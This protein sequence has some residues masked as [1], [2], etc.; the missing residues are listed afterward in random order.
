M[1]KTAYFVL[2]FIIVIIM[3]GYSAK[4]SAEIFATLGIGTTLINSTLKVADVGYNYNGWEIQGTLIE[5]GTTKN[6]PQDY[7]KLASLSYL[8]EPS[9]GYMGVEPYFRLG[10][11]YNPDSNL[12]GT[13][14][15]K[16]GI[17]VDFNEVFRVEYTHH[18]SAGIHSPNTGIDYVTIVYRLPNPW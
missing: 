14:N 10:L 7:L 15:F 9:W 1:K 5:R 12:V 16:L 17:G 6:G 11:S 4:S 3:A 13:S 8:V 18:S 2:A